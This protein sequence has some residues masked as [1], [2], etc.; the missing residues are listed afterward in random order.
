MHETMC[1]CI[2][3]YPETEILLKQSQIRLE[4][5]PIY[6][7]WLDTSW[8]RGRGWGR[9]LLSGRAAAYCDID[10]LDLG[11]S[12]FFRTSPEKLYHR[13]VTSIL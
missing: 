2:I 5:P 9:G 6:R 11:D 8:R 12:R 3:L 7:R 4:I 10:L 1:T 13:T